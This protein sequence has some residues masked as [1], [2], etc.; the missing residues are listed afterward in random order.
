[1]AEK[2]DEALVTVLVENETEVSA[3]ISVTH[4]QWLRMEEHLGRASTNWRR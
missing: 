3:P 4:I 1:M 2:G